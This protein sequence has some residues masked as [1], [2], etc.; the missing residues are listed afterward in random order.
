[1]TGLAPA[2]G[3]LLGALG[4]A[5][6][7]IEFAGAGQTAVS[8]PLLVYPLLFGSALTGLT[9]LPGVRPSAA[10]RLRALAIAAAL[11]SALA[12]LGSVLVGD[13]SGLAYAGWLAF[14][15]G[16]IALS[17]IA[18]AFGI[19]HV[20]RVGLRGIA[21]LAIIASLAPV[22]VAGIGLV[23]KSLTGWWVT[24]PELIRIGEVAAAVSIGGGWLVLGVGIV[25]T[26]L[27]SSRR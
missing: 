13:E 6:W 18:L 4:G 24:D 22:V 2:I 8:V 14:V 25:V 23:Y 12:Y 20:R 10:G 19:A 7:L 1:V 21:W 15:G 11:G 9:L 16:L 27:I 17:V 26:S 5:L 3:G